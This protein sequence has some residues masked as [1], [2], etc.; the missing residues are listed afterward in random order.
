MSRARGSVGVGRSKASGVMRVLRRQWFLVLI[1][2]VAAAGFLISVVGPETALGR[3]AGGAA[4]WIGLGAFLHERLYHRALKYRLT[5]DRLRALTS[6]GE[7]RWEITAEFDVDEPGAALTETRAA[8]RSLRADVDDVSEDLRSSVWR[9]DDVVVKASVTS[10]SGHDD[11]SYV[12]TVEMVR[13][14]RPYRGLLRTLERTISPLFES[15][16]DRVAPSKSK[17]VSTVE[18]ERGNPYFGLFVTG[19]EPGLVGRFDLML[20][21][22]TARGRDPVYVTKDSIKVVTTSLHAAERL[23]R[24]YL[25]LREPDGTAA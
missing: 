2:L 3:W 22:E 15:I 4:M 25:G 8:V 9:I 1:L 6:T 17:F 7:V 20:Y 11:G 21:E 24:Q 18:F 12:L 5:I 10:S 19:L 13:A 14:T 23:S 16:V